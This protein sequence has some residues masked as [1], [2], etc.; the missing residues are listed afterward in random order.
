MDAYLCSIQVHGKSG[1]MIKKHISISKQAQEIFNTV[2]NANI[3][4][5]KMFYKHFKNPYLAENPVRIEYDNEIPV[6]M[7]AFMGAYLKY[8][9]EIYYI[10]QS[11][12]TAV[13]ESQRGKKIFSKIVTKEEQTEGESYFIFGFPNQNSYPGFI[14]MG[15]KEIAVF[16]QFILPVHPFKFIFGQNKIQKFLDKGIEKIVLRKIKK[17]L[18]KDEIL[19]VSNTVPFTDEE[20]RIINENSEVGFVRSIDFYQWKIDHNKGNEFQYVVLKKNS[21]LVG[22][23]IYHLKKAHNGSVMVIDDWLAIGKEVYDKESVL[24]KIIYNIDEHKDMVQVP[25]INTRT[26]EKLLWK[27]LYFWDIRTLSR[28]YKGNP[29]VISPKGQELAFMQ[30][31]EVRNIDSDTILN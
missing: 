27:S 5:E 21:N 19:I 26:Y 10:L 29:L 1:Y 14:K 20:I 22:Y 17:N 15:W 4:E 7:N 18:A 2:Y 16:T 31:C 24:K 23:L 30:Y 3:S 6:G 28:N 13:L 25:L 12:D 8:K 9:K 11:C